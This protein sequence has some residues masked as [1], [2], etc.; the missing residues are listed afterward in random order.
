MIVD[1]DGR[2][3]FLDVNVMPGLTETSLLP[4]A[5]KST[6][7]DLG[8]AYAALTRRAVAQP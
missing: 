7:Q 6:G 5:L 4:Q 1:A 3:W 2:P 8:A